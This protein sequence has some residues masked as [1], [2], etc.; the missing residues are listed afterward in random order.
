MKN[1]SD[2][3]KQELAI[4]GRYPARH[5]HNPVAWRN[6]ETGRYGNVVRDPHNH[7]RLGEIE[8]GRMVRDRLAALLEQTDLT[9]AMIDAAMASPRHLNR[10]I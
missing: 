8:F 6:P 5:K 2:I 9:I 7:L 4:P 1:A 10:N 3:R